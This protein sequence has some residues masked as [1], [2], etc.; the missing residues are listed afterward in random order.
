MSWGYAQTGLGN[1]WSLTCPPR[2]LTSHD[3]MPDRGGGPVRLWL[4]IP[5]TATLHRGCIVA[6]IPQLESLLLRASHWD[7]VSPQD[8]IPLF[9]VF[10]EEL[11]GQLQQQ[12]LSEPAVVQTRASRK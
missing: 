9:K 11:L 10:V 6:F 12:A 3:L 7:P 2:L 4:Q 1:G 5:K 8:P